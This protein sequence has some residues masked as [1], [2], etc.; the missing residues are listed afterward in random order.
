VTLS[1]GRSC[2]LKHFDTRYRDKD[3]SLALLYLIDKNDI[4]YLMIFEITEVK[5]AMTDNEGIRSYVLNSQKSSLNEQLLC[6]L[7]EEERKKK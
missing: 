3:A 1:N 6:L 2:V 5:I 7:K 4:E